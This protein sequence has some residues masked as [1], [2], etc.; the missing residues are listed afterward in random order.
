MFSLE[1]YTGFGSGAWLEESSGHGGLEEELGDE[2][3]LNSGDWRLESR[4]RRRAETR[5]KGSLVV[6]ALHY[7]RG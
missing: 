2:N 3:R 1:G 4:E 7:R 5:E 6:V